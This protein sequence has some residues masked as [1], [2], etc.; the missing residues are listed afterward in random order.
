ML[1]AVTRD[2]GG[3]CLTPVRGRSCRLS[4]RVPRALGARKRRATA[5]KDRYILS[6]VEVEVVASSVRVG[7]RQ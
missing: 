4:T 7:N 3:R 1:L 2:N 5:T 6:C